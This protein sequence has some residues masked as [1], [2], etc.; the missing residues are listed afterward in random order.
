MSSQ[1]D[2]TPCTLLWNINDQLVDVAK[3]SI[4]NPLDHM[5]HNFRMPDNIFRVTVSHVLSYDY[6]KLP[7]PVAGTGDEDATH[8]GG[9][10]GWMIMWQKSL[11]RAE[12]AGVTLI[13]GN[14]TI[15]PPIQLPSF[16][17]GDQRGCEEGPTVP[18]ADR[19][20]PV[21]PQDDDM[22]DENPD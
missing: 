5:L 13:Q 21:D 7:L 14:T 18:V 15:T 19:A 1:A 11:N 3:V 16:V 12:I 6:S 9:S 10:K 4:L 8:L 20:A 2:N 22:H 17:L